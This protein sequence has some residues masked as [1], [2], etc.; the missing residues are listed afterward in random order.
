MR[1]RKE[2]YTFQT[3][4]PLLSQADVT[5]AIGAIIFA[6]HISV[7]VILFIV[8]HPV[9]VPRELLSFRL[10]LSC[11]E[12]HLIQLLI[13]ARKASLLGKYLPQEM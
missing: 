4:F 12:W 11:T 7:F 8:F 6:S 1:T 2:W 9:V 10:S 3:L 13:L 5:R